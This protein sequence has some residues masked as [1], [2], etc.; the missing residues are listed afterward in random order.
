MPDRTESSM[1]I[2][3]P[4]PH[5]VEVLAD[6]PA[7]AS[8]NRE[9][10]QV[11]V[12]STEG[13]GWPDRVRFE[14][15]TGMIKDTYVLDYDWHIAHDGTGSLS[16][17][18]VEARTLRDLVGSYTITSSPSGTLVTYRLTLRPKVPMLGALRRKVEQMVVTSS[19]TSLRERVLQVHPATPEGE[20][21]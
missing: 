9:V 14:L 21:P 20:T 6:F 12:L 8:W 16:W 13:D 3:A 10:K 11:E 1:Q 7:Y 15:D 17:E 5:V 19:L 2:P 4:A 18:M